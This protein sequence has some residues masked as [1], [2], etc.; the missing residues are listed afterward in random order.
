LNNAP[1]NFPSPP[2]IPKD[3]VPTP[4]QRINR[5]T[6]NILI[7]LSSTALLTVVSGYFQPPPPDEGTAAHIFQ[8][9]VAALFPTIM[10][11]F[12]TADRGR[13]VR[14]VRPLVFPAAALIVAFAALF[15]LEHHR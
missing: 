11:F 12:I 15:Y 8:L 1:E 14:S 10:I 9:S 7:V 6:R 2:T 13:P 4:S 5:L 3:S